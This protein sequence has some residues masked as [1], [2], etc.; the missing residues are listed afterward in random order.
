MKYVFFVLLILAAI[1]M[2]I[3]CPVYHRCP[4]CHAA[5]KQYWFQMGLPGQLS[6]TCKVCGK[7]LIWCN[8]EESG[9]SDERD[10]DL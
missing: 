2:T 1:V 6:Y 10:A 3:T 4:D 8:K 7:N 5:Y 9:W